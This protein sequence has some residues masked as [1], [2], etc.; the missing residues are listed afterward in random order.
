MPQSRA[1]LLFDAADVAE[2]VVFV[3]E[4]EAGERDRAGQRVSG[5]R[6]AVEEGPAAVVAQERVVDCIG[7]DSRA[8]RQIA[9]G[10]RLRQADHVRRDPG[11]LA[12]EHAARAAKPGEHFV[13]DQ[14]RAV[15]IAQPADSR[16]ELGGPHII[17]PAPCSIGSTMTAAT[18]PPCSASFASRSPQA[19]DGAPLA[20][21]SH[22]QRKQYGAC[23]RT[24]GKRRGANA[25]VKIDSSLTD[26]APTVSP[27]YA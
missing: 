11:M 3:E 27:W 18:V 17:P 14:Q 19:V 8:E 20:G 16:Q 13:G 5:V 9:G 21:Q 1:K 26:I 10:Q 22:G 25:R 24:T 4:V 23:T 2:H 6:M 12:C 15:S 7:D